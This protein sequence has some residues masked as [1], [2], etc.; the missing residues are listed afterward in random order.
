MLMIR[1][2]TLKLC[3]RWTIFIAPLARVVQFL[4]S[5]SGPLRGC[6]LCVSQDGTIAVV[7]VDGFQLYVCATGAL[8]D[9]S[10]DCHA[11][12]LYLIPGASSPLLRVC[13]GEDNLLLFYANH[14]ARLWDVK[15]KEFWRSMTIEKAEEILHQGGWTDMFVLHFVSL[16]FAYDR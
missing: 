10:A 13:L 15:T 9:L 7:A 2:S 11:N 5:Q 8:I 14:R 4:D 1:F 3:A 12:S 6:V 16:I